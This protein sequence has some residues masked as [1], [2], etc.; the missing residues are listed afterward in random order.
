MIDDSGTFSGAAA[1][2][3]KEETG[4]SF[5]ESELIDLTALASSS[6][7]QSPSSS[8]KS[9]IKEDLQ[10]AIYPSPGACDEFIPIFLCR[11]RLPRSQLEEMQGK[12]TGLREHGEKITLKIVR[13]GELWREGCRDGKTLAAWALYQGLR[14][15]GRV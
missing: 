1:K 9:E 12:L 5:T 11:K 10:Q 13:L 8:S 2:E 4:L 3:L 14:G 15:E 7:S 6:P